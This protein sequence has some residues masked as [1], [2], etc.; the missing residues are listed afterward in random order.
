M[1]QLKLSF[2]QPIIEQLFRET[3]IIDGYTCYL[4]REHGN[5]LI[6]LVGLNLLG[7]YSGNVLFQFS[8][9]FSNEYAQYPNRQQLNDLNLLS[10]DEI[11]TFI[12]EI[13][14]NYKQKKYKWNNKYRCNEY[15]TI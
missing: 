12:K 9:Q 3:I 2:D 4:D 10:F 15:K 14:L 8:N 7:E 11:I 6:T 13:L 1:I 5:T